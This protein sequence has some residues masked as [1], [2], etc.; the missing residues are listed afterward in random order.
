MTLGTEARQGPLSMGFSSPEYRSELA[1]P[2]S[3]DL[4]TQ[5]LNL[6]LLHLLHW[7]VCSLPLG[8]PRKPSNILTSLLEHFS[9]DIQDPYVSHVHLFC[10]NQNKSFSMWFFILSIFEV[11][12]SVPPTPTSYPIGNN[13]HCDCQCQ[14]GSVIES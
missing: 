3:R 9:V 14:L 12:I 10:F 6:C 4:P 5:G 2:S 7:Q 8:L 13:C 11:L 1:M